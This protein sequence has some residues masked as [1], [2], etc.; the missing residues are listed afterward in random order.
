MA[1]KA[2]LKQ[3]MIFCKASTFYR[4][5]RFDERMQRMTERP[6][7]PGNLQAIDSR[8][9][10]RR[11]TP[12]V[13]AVAISILIHAAGFWWLTGR[14]TPLPPATMAGDQDWITI[15]LVAP[16]A[17]MPA[18]PPPA[19][20]MPP[21]KARPESKAP[22]RLPAPRKE[23]KR[24]H[25]AEP[26]PVVKAP[27]ATPS[28]VA[29]SA[30]SPPPVAAVPDDMSSM[31]EAA[32]KRRAAARGQDYPAADGSEPA[33][34]DEA[35]RANRIVRANVAAAQIGA[36]GVDRDQHGGVFQ[37]RR[38][39]LHDAEFMFRGWNTGFGRN[40]SQLITVE[41][42]A[43]S[44]IRIAVVK[45]MIGLIRS[46]KTDEF[47]WNSHRLGKELML[48]AKPEH[49]SELQQFLLRE[50][51]PDYVQTARLDHNP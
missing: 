39:G 34:E 12:V 30:P 15:A 3:G 35:Q 14:V 51:F 42:G 29:P 13:I 23:R 37:I 27:A 26:A 16:A 50:F 40:S 41:Q 17:T 11:R 36:K 47:V 45:K 49:E 8:A 31:L 10:F 4:N 5:D 48:S 7:D 38:V 24:L 19:P 33:P 43:S 46:K 9:P 32:R 18:T 44:D 1:V 6:L 20:A 28:I 22:P 21:A 2:V 25:A